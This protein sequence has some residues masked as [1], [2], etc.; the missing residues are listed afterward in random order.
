MDKEKTRRTTGGWLSDPVPVAGDGTR[1]GGEKPLDALYLHVPFCRSRCRYCSFVTCALAGDD[2]LVGSYCDAL[3]L[4]LRRATKT[5]LLA[6]IASAYVGG[7]T[8]THVAARNLS[9]LL[10][11]LGVLVPRD[12][13]TFE[14]TVEANPE[15]VTPELARD[16]FMLGANR[17]SLGVQT[18]DDALLA[19][20][21]RPH[22]A[23]QARRAASALMERGARCSADLICGIPGQSMERWEADLAGV[24][25]MGV[26]H[27][28]VYPLTVE[29][30]T[31]LAADV[32]SGL[33]SSPDD[34][35]QADMMLAA[36]DALGS[37]GLSRYE[38]ASYARH[39]CEARHNLAYWTGKTYLGLGIG[40]ASML[41]PGQFAAL[42]DR[43]VFDLVDA[44]GDPLPKP[45]APTDGEPAVRIRL[46]ALPA[47]GTDGGRVLD[48]AVRREAARFA[49]T[50]SMRVTAECLSARQ[51]AAEDLMLGMRLVRGVTSAQLDEW[52]PLLPRMDET[53]AGLEADG[54]LARI[55]AA[56]EESHPRIAPTTRGWLLGNE[57]FERLWDLA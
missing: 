1:H 31:P 48:E 51:A 8:P 43:R 14:L 46:S 27:V 24:L 55:P 15:S 23:E 34:D 18:L 9:S 50:M 11:L 33:V 37:A 3:A 36:Q 16:L 19:A 17:F 21:G 39:G 52:R 38:V 57:L 4:C 35:R 7:G 28:S 25:A 26:D 32:A 20:L 10:Y 30:G 5:G 44:H 13:D 49:E 12:E 53:L 40:A 29:Q 47:G 45:P 6:S 42:A 54:L 41:T 56:D 2:A 22:T